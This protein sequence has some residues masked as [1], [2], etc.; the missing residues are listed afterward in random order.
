LT[1]GSLG[2]LAF[3]LNGRGDFRGAEVAGREALALFRKQPA[4]RQVATTLTALGNALAGQHRF[5]EAVLHLREAHDIFEKT[6]PLRTPWYKPLTQS[7]LG[8]ALAGTGDRVGAERLLLAGYE[9]LRD[10]PSTPPLQVRAAIERLVAFYVASGRRDE[11]AAWRGRL[12]GLAATETRAG[13]ASA[14]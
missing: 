6:P 9:G 4:D 11:A 12:P 10:L 1:K 2:G 14:R 8:T 5:E 7:S 3:A 13:S